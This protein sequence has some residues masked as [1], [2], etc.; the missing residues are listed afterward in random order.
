MIN[1]N[2]IYLGFFIS[3]AGGITYLV[4]T[5]KGKAKPNRISWFFWFLAPF[6]AFAAEVQKGVG[7]QALMTFSVGFNPL[8]VFLASFINKNAYWKLSK[9]DYIYGALALLGIIL[10]K[11]TGEG[12]IAILFAILA[13]GLASIPTIIKSYKNPETE[14]STLFLLSLINATITLLTIKTWTFAHW[15]FPVYIFVIDAI[16]YSLIRFVIGKHI[17]KIFT[18]Q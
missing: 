17:S 2:F 15:G 3:F 18:T 12:N 1:E 13:D 6:I 16:I 10:W 5:I 14:S 4:D 7:L 11:M 8:L 9:T